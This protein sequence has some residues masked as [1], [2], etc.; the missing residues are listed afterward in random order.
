MENPNT[1]PDQDV[2]AN[3]AS[4]QQKSTPWK[5]ATG[6]VNTCWQCDAPDIRGVQRIV[7]DP[8]ESN[9]V[10]VTYDPVRT[11]TFTMAEY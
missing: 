4:L 5:I 6:V 1:R 9:A 7:E 11:A 2:V 3:D 8:V 10:Q